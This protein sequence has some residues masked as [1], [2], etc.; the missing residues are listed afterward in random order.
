M[1]F[2]VIIAGAGP[3][4][5]MLAGELRL[6]GVGALVLERLPEPS[7]EA[8]ANGLVGQVVPMMDRRSLYERLGGPPGAPQPNS[9]YFMFASLPLDL[10]LLDHSPIYALAAPQSRQVEVLRDR[11]LELGAEIR[12]STELLGFEQDENGVTVEV[13]DADGVHRLRAAYLVSAGGAHSVIRKMSGIDFPGMHYDRTL[14]RIANANLPSE[15]IDPATGTLHVPGYGDIRPFLPFRTERGGFAYAPF[16]GRPPL[17]ST[18]E[19]D[20]AEPADPMG[21]DEMAASIA[22][23][24]GVPLPLEPPTGDGPYA[25]WR[26]VGGHTRVAERFRDRRIFLAGDAAHIF[27]TG[28]GPGLNLGLQDALNLGWKLAAAIK[29]EA[30]AGLLDSY[31]AERGRAARRTLLSAQAQAALQAPGSDVTALREVFSELLADH[32]AVQRIADL[33]AGS[34][35]RYDM[36]DPDPNPLVGRI[37]PDV[38]L[39]IA[40]RT[41]RL[42]ELARTARPLLIDLTEDGELSDALPQQPGRVE[43]VR[44]RVDRATPAPTALLLRPDTYV[45]WATSMPHP[46]AAEL[47]ALR[48]ALTRWFGASDNARVDEIFSGGV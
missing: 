27:A 26:M 40:D 23:V 6:A 10:S 39:H 1:T 12:W 8:K 48:A 36:G 45:A 2:D 9:A 5:L 28:G 35:I 19:W 46:D 38:E 24:L 25:L 4:G 32:A 21:L 13:S 33:L 18:V 30:P 34:D 15:W 29:G 44:A 11:A 3:V 22:R 37:A 47:E 17:L 31:D 14:T 43:T 42:A 41:V 7:G 20:E 16:P